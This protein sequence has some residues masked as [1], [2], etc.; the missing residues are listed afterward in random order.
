MEHL[1]MIP[2]I[3]NGKSDENSN[4]KIYKANVLFTDGRPWNDHGR[5]R[6]RTKEES[7]V[8]ALFGLSLSCPLVTT[9]LSESA[10]HT[11]LAQLSKR[12]DSGS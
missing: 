10:R 8:S 1:N 2:R 7:L 11:G 6:Q 9:H 4:G 5:A 3:F 12:T